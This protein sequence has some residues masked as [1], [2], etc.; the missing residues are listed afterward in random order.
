MAKFYCIIKLTKTHQVY[1]AQII[2][3]IKWLGRTSP[4]HQFTNPGHDKLTYFRS[5]DSYFSYIETFNI[6][7]NVPLFLY[8]GQFTVG[9]C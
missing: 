1:Y 2:S 8:Q 6:N 9:T 3:L 7:L 4:F 5:W